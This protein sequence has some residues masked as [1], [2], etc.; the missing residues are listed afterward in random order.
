MMRRI[1]SLLSVL[2]LL[3][4]SL[5]LLTSSL[6]PLAGVAAAAPKSQKQGRARKVAP[7]LS[8]SAAAV[9]SQ[10]V[11]VIIQTKGRPTQAHEG[12]IRAKGGAKRQ[13]LNALEALTAD[14]PASAVAEL[15]AREDVL[16]VSP[17]RT[18]K[19]ALDV[20]RDTTGAAQVQGGSKG[21]QGL[22]GK[23]VGIA[24]IDSGIS[25]RHPDFQKNKTRVVAAV[26]F[27][28]EGGG[29]NANGIMLGDGIMLAD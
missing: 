6:A 27:T 1:T 11:R 16:Y 29:A 7:E 22:T 28:G 23:G 18:V 10:T 12:A 2:A 15:A 19:A 21:A 9:S 26:N 20:T 4:T 24:V 17:D 25:A 13:S 3:T 8:G 14:V 5:A